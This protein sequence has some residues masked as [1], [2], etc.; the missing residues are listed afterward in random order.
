MRAPQQGTLSGQQ[1]PNVAQSTPQQHCGVVEVQVAFPLQGIPL[2]DF[3]A[4]APQVDPAG[5]GGGEGAPRRG[6]GGLA[7][8]G[9]GGGGRR[10]LGGWFL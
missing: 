7:V 2:Q 9:G 10:F 3:G 4:V 5:G 1:S 8:K 6:G